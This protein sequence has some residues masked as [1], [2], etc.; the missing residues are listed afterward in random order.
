MNTIGLLSGIGCLG[1]AVLMLRMA[2]QEFINKRLVAA[3]K[4]TSIGNLRPGLNLT[5]GEVVCHDPIKTPYTGTPAAWYRYTATKRQP[6]Q[7]S[8][9]LEERSIGSGSLSCP[10]FIKDN[11]GEVEVVGTGGEVTSFPRTRVLKSRSGASTSLKDRMKKL[12]EM[13]NENASE[14]GKKPF[15]RKIEAE[16]TPLDVPPDLVEI[17]GD[18]KE[19]QKTE[20]K[21]YESWIQNGDYVYVMGTLVKDDTTAAPRIVKAAKKSPLFVSRDAEDMDKNVFQSNFI[22]G[23]L[24]GA[25]MALV[26]I[27]LVLIGLGVVEV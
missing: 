24:V 16:G 10:F 5:G 15:F 9:K 26:G 23:L 11:T 18:S 27:V 22:T 7:S 2:K 14:S 13:D 19:A 20:K 4:M 12:K 8:A 21:Y 17:D 25:G 3:L 6:S 1:G